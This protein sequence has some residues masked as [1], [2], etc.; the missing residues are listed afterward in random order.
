[1]ISVVFPGNAVLILFGSI[2]ESLSSDSN[3][4]LTITEIGTILLFINLN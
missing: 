4:F 1:L 3:N 2:Y